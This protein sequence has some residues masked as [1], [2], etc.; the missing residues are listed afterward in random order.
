MI[1]PLAQK[2]EHELSVCP[3]TFATLTFEHTRTEGGSLRFP[4]FHAS[5]QSLHDSGVAVAGIARGTN[6]D[7]MPQAP[8]A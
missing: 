3:W 8:T 7:K 4:T 6:A 1:S 5:L 2:S